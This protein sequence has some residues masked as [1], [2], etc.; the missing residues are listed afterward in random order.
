MSSVVTLPLHFLVAY[1]IKMSVKSPS[2]VEVCA[3][4]SY[5]CDYHLIDI[6][7]SSNQ[8]RDG[9]EPAT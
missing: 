2:Q 7:I 6:L 8:K 3:T 4:K 5:G 1:V 9:V